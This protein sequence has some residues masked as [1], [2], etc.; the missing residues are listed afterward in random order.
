MS[1]WFSYFRSPTPNNNE[2]PQPGTSE[3]I[4]TISETIDGLTQEQK[5]HINEVLNRAERSKQN[6][7]VVMDQYQL[8]GLRERGSISESSIDIEDEDDLLEM[9]PLP[10]SVQVS[11]GQ[12]TSREVSPFPQSDMSI[13]DLSASCRSY[14]PSITVENAPETTEDDLNIVS[15]GMKLLS[16]KIVE[17]VTNLDD[18]Y[19][20]NSKQQHDDKEAEL[21][22]EGSLLDDYTTNFTRCVIIIAL[23]DV[24]TIRR[25]KKESLN[26]HLQQLAENLSRQAISSAYANFKPTASNKDQSNI[27]HDLVESIVQESLETA[28]AEYY[29]HEQKD[30]D[31]PYGVLINSS[32]TATFNQQYSLSTINHTSISDSTE[33]E[34]TSSDP[35]D[36]EKASDAAITLN[37]TGNSISAN[38]TRLK[39]D[40]NQHLKEGVD[41]SGATKDNIF[42]IESPSTT[43]NEQSEE[44]T[45][46]ATSGAD[47]EA[48]FESQGSVIAGDSFEDHGLLAESPVKEAPPLPPPPVLIQKEELTTEEL[49]HIERVRRLAEGLEMTPVE[50]PEIREAVLEFR[51]A[52][53]EF[54]EAE[55]E[56]RE[57]EPEF[58]EA[59]PEFKEAEPMLER[60]SSSATSGADEEAGFESQGSVIAGDSFEDHGLLAESPVKEAPPLPPLPV[61][62]QK[63]ELT[64]EELEHIERVRRL[65]EGLEMTSTYVEEPE[66][67]EAEPEFREAEPEFKEAEPEFK[68]AEPML[69]RT[70]SSATSGADEEARFESQGSVIAGDSFEDHGLLA[71]SPVK[72]APP[73]PPPPVLIQKEELT[74]EELEHIERV[75]RLAEG[76]EMTSTYVEEP[77]IKEAE[78]EFRE[79][80]PDFKEAE[81]MLERTASSATSGGDEEARF[82]SQGSVIAGD[83][84]EDHGLLAESPVKEA[85]P[86]VLIQKEELTA[87]ELEHIERVRRLA[88]G[89]EMTSTYV[90][91]P[92]IREAE[93]E[94]REAEPEFKEAEPEFKEAEP[95]L[96]RT[97]SSATSGADEE[98][99]FESQ[100]SVIAG[101]SFEDHGLLAESPV[102]EAPPL[103]PPPVFIQ[104]EEL[105]A[106]ELEHIERVRRLAE[107][108]E[109]T[110]TYVEEPEIREAEPMLERTASSATS[111]ADEEARFESQGSVIA[112]DSFED[113][114]LLAESPVKEAPPLPPPVLIQKEELTAEELEHIERV[115]RL[116]EGLE[117]TSTYVEEP[118]I[119]EAEPEFREAEPEFK[120]AE[121]MLERTAS[122]ATS[123]ADEEARFESQGSVIAGDSFEDHGLLAESPVKEAPPLPP[124]VL[125]Q[126]EELT[127]EELEHIERVRRLAEGLEMTSTYVEEPEIRE[128]EPEFREAEPEFKEAEPEFKEA[129][130]MLERTASSA[131]SGADEE[132]RFESQG[133]VIAGDSFEDHGLLAES[134]VKEAPPL[135]P[136]PVFIQKEELTAEELEHIERVRRLAE[137]LEMTSTYVEEPEIREAEPM[138]ERTASS[139]TSG[140]D[141]EARFESQGSVIAGDS[142]EDHGLLAESPV[143]EAPPLPPP[144]LIQKEELTAEELEHIERV[145]RLAEGLEMTSTYVEEPEIR[146]AEPEFREAEP[147]FKE[148]EP[149]LERTASSATSG[150]DEEARFESQ[151]SVIAGDSFE[152]HG[153]LAESPVKEA[154]PLPPPVLIQKEE[155]TAEE[156]EHIERVRRL[157]EG[158]EMTSTY[159]EEPEIREAEPEF[160]EAEPEFKEAEPEFKEAEP[161]LERTASSATSGAD[162]EARFESQGSV[163]AGDSFEDHGLLA[164]SP[165]KEAPPLP[166]PPVFIQKEEL[167]AE[168]LEH[169]ERVR[170]LAEGLE[171]TST[172]VEEPEI[173]EAEPM[174]ERTASSATSGADEEARFESQGSVIA[175]DS[176]EDHGLLAESPVKE[177]PPL[178]P[179]VL[180][181]KEELTAEELEHI[182]RVRRLAEGLEMTSTYVE[183]PEIREAEPEFREAEPE[184][185]EA[186]PMLE[187]TASSATSGA[188]EEARFESQGSV[189][190]VLIQK[191]ELTAEELEHIERVRR[192]AEGLEMTSTYVEEPEI[193]EAEPEFR[194]AEPDFKEAEPMLERTAS[195]ATS[196]ADEEARFESQGSV[197]AGDSFEDH[198]LLAE[199]PVKEAPPL[200]PPV[201]I[202]KEELTAEELEHIERVRRLAEGLEMTSTYVEEPEIREA[203]PEFREAEPE[204]KEAEPM[205][206]RT[207][208]SATSGAD[209]EARFESQGSVIAGDSFEDH[210]LLA[211]SPVKEAPPLP[212]PVLIQKEELT[213]EE[214]EHIERVRR[215]AEG[216]EMT[217]TYVE[218]PEIKEAEPEFREAEPDFKEAEPMLERTASSATSGAD[219]EARFESQGSVIAGDSFEDHGLL[220]ESPV[221]EAP[222]LPPP[223]LIQKEEL[224]AEELEHIERVR[225]LAEGLEMTSTYVEEPEIKEAEPEFR[226]AEPDFKEAEPMLER[227]ASSATSGGDEEARFESQ[228]SVI[229]GDSFEDHGLLAESPVKEAPPLPPPPVLIQKEEL[230]A[231]ELEHIERVRRLAEGLEMTSTYV[232]EPEIR[233][234]EP[235]LERTASSATSGADEEA[236]F[237]SQGSVIAGDSFEDHGLLAE[238]PVKEA[239]PLPPPPV[240]IQKEELTAEELEHIERVRRLAEG[241]EMTSTYVEEPEIKEAEPEFKEAEPEFKEAEPMLERTSSSA[242]SGA[243]EEAG[244]ESQGSVIAGDSFED[245]GLLAESP[246]KEAPPLPPP[247]VLI[248][249]E[250]LTAEELEHIE[251][252]RR[253]AEG[254]EMT[255]TYVEEPE[256]REAEPEFREAEPDFKE[257]EPMLERTASSATSG[258]DEEARFE[259]QGSVIAG[260]SF[261]DHGLLAESPVKE[262]PPL[263][264][265]VL[266]QKEELTAEEPEHI[267][268]VRRLAEGLE[269]TSTYVEEPEIKE[270]EPEFRE[271]EPDFKEAEPMLERTASSATSGADEE[272]R[273]ESQ[274]SVIAGDSFEDHGLLAESPVKEAPPLPPPVLIQKEELTAEELEHIE[275]VRRLAEGLEMTSTYV[276]EPEIREAEPEFREAEP[277][278]KEAEPM[279]ERTASSAT[280]GAD[281][282]ARFESQGSVIAGDSFEDHGLLAESPVKEAPP[283]PPPVLIQKEELTAEEL[284][285]IERVRRLAEGLEM[286]STY[287]EEPEIKEAEPE[288]REAEPDFKEAEPMLERTASSATSGADEEARF[289]SQGSVIA[290]DS[291]EDHGLLAESPVKEAPPLPPPVLIQKEELTA[292][293]LEHIERVRR[294]AEGLE[295]TSTYVEEPEIKEAEPEFREAEPDFKEAEPMLERTASSATSGGDEEAR[296]ESQGSVIAGD[297]FEDHGLLAES[298][299]KEAPPLPPPPVLIQKEEL[300]AEELEHIERVRR[301]AEGL[302]MTSTYV[303]EPEIR[304]AEPMLER[305]AS[306]ATSG[307]DEEARFESQGSVIAGDSFEDHGLLAESPVKEAPPLPPPPVLI[308]K[309]ELTAEELEH[310]ERVRRLAEGLEMTSTYVEEPE[311]KEAEPE[312]KEAEPEF[313]EAEP[314]LE[315]TSSSATSGADEEA[316]FESQ[317]SV[318]AGDSFEDHG[319]LAESPVKEAPPLPPPPVL[320]QKEELTAEELEH[321]ERVRRLAEGLE[322]TSTYVEEPEIREAEPEFREAEPDFK[323]AEP[324]LERTASS[325]TS[326]GDEEARFESQGSVI[327]GDSFED[328]GLLAESPVKEAPPL[329]PP[330]LI[331]K[332]ELTA[333]EPEHIERVRRLAEGL[334]MTSTYVEE[335]EIREAE[336][337]LERT[338][339]S[340]TSGADE[341][342]RFESQGSVIAGDSFE[343]HGLLAESPVKEAPPL[344]P[345]VLIQK[346][347]LTAEE[348]EHIERVR[349]L[350]EGLEMTSTYVEEPEIKEAEP[351][352]REAEPDF[353]EAEPMLE[354][355]ASS[356]TSGG[357]EEARF[358]SQGSVI[359]GDS[360]ED[361]GLLA[362]SPVKEAP[363]L[364]PPPVL[365]QKEELTAEELEHI[366]RVRRLAEGL[367]MTSTYVEEPEIREAEPMLERT[368][369]S[370]TSGADEEARFESQGSVIAGDSFED[371]GLLAESPVK[372]APPLPPPPVLIQKEELTA[373]ELEHIERV[374]RLAEGLEMTSTYVEEPEIK[375]AE[376]EFREAEPD[377]KEAEPMLER[378]ASSATSGGD[379]EARF[380]SQ[381]SVIAGDSFEDHGLLAESPV[382]EAPPLPPPPVL[383]QKEELTAEE[384]E[385]IERVRRL[386]EG[387]EMTSTYVEEPEIKE[388]EPEFREAEP[389]FKEAEPMLERTASSAT[390]GGDEEA[391]FESQGSVIAGDSFEDH[392]LLAE[393]PVKEAP[394]LPPPPV[395]IQKE[396]LTAEELEH[397]ERVRR[398]AEGLEMTSTYVEEPEIREAEPEF[399]EA[400]PEFKEAE[401]M[402]ERTA[403]SATSG[404]DEEA[405]FESQGSVI[406]GDS[407]EDHG[408][409]AESPVKEAP[410]STTTSSFDS[411]RGVDSRRART[412]RTGTTTG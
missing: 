194:E 114:G 317:G 102:K 95:M 356:A 276:E 322:M 133:S 363:P 235:M 80:E 288:F 271:A 362:E 364:P 164:E 87:E 16:N 174:L 25:I 223:V 23:A 171:M 18:D 385:H 395:L 170:R 377:F 198:G 267:E 265:P 28:I 353:K 33:I 258:G 54:R 352:F 346:E 153:L 301:L 201:L 161:M 14:T 135:P 19:G 298:P 282:E 407:F 314:M 112:G 37:I 61:L 335:P 392:G 342:A 264:P 144:V 279:L 203:E 36:N 83:S 299:V 35:G 249:K 88:E 182:E 69:E 186:E 368:A 217:S 358:E 111:G 311:I 319:L 396:E 157:A 82:E 212:P 367:E 131:T 109:M 12:G 22:Y 156:L 372:E 74:A 129:E 91:E 188:D 400:E 274:G 393:S 77:E 145:R 239:P 150:A 325:A 255:S 209:E 117:M 406:A 30:Y 93:P 97:A 197:I 192:L 247:P 241:L 178:P 130:P 330:V 81:P 66:I 108:L 3:Q 320:I 308:Q 296:F 339:S 38:I 262:A 285:H 113:H 266:I 411:K 76:L 64:A 46:S 245:H 34:S 256:I 410:T 103:P 326:G 65:A 51:E 139:A 250:E 206:E 348:L 374:R 303:E 272:A 361:H 75:R 332:E 387:L 17:W 62:I 328:H 351:E 334:E 123:G 214:L 224:T 57:A 196:G 237:E 404:G 403:S 221:K 354:R 371:H 312:F 281:E 172:Y 177:A 6:V 55:P 207:A 202:Q 248:Q 181:Q 162:E 389:D 270:A 305:T 31:L 185:K 205:L 119:R 230:T 297:S 183:E 158:L 190:A 187:R 10:K 318:I 304:E 337:M 208:S 39:Q 159:V 40:L 268:R 306:S 15:K 70:A 107:G 127:A 408:L 370:A 238:S 49:E 402:L 199:S 200:P 42:K 121:P 283:L 20:I 193:K 26:I 375:E 136:P 391:R 151:G 85:P 360:F 321:I 84:F 141:E 8:R 329:P 315:R 173:R 63:E 100:G 398:L 291:F 381:G 243:D 302:E 89:L 11:V 388:A 260:D 275:R 149:M 44:T 244:F 143:K 345:P 366:E 287:V 269:M 379:E 41:G 397:I 48:R 289:E 382:K 236:R 409:L 125:I 72:E 179:P 60:T 231:E 384:L 327:A 257:A 45:S 251:R 7:R 252:V 126:K 134:P 152:D 307:A 344:P 13:D 132:A 220:A 138:L 278:F 376:P 273:F 227:T 122:S 94:F 27:Q 232:E 53:P 225:R 355:T 290:G 293:E 215:L 240:L 5:Q 47:E 365:I 110:S 128:A 300:T 191:E 32:A 168:E 261:E 163:I 211:E 148:A 309:E 380:E 195:S 50:E 154:P 137:G 412:H 222:P 106:E 118:E 79:A 359:A 390:S 295:M 253:L 316:G 210:G 120:E 4:Q 142:F 313:K 96:E 59:E 347:E 383:I 116:A 226:E 218:E 105:T 294:L 98:A 213:A 155:L 24:T 394:P 176:F 90:E 349:R 284:E 254:L 333:E 331:Q 292:E 246:V 340:A 378:T 338:A 234:A 350:A 204:F 175:G 219:E 115:R 369:S 310:I 29:L 259:S 286:T 73:L 336:P 101:D 324:M 233:E 280:S 323:E 68:E 184:F 9:D 180:I 52:E 56:F 399:R 165:V 228:G 140:A 242:T 277:E 166:P 263:P 341:E 104:K 67:R 147:E 160:R 1:S 86:P 2:D 169:I 146:E 189:I 229:A 21:F 71:E 58:K 124:P 78:P 216:L 386:A 405:R 401:P 357:D 373:E 167:T 343:D 43:E 99:R 92:E